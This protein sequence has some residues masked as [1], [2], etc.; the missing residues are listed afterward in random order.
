MTS[1]RKPQKTNRDESTPAEIPRE[2]DVPD[3]SATK[4]RKITPVVFAK[5]NRE[6]SDVLFVLGSSGGDW[7]AVAKLFHQKLAPIILVNGLTGKKYDETGQPLAH[8]IRDEL[9]GFG[10]PPS[11]ILTQDKS[12]NTLEDVKFGKELLKRHG[13]NP[14]TI[15]FVS[16]SHHSGRVLLTLKRFFPATLL[17]AVTYDAIYEGAKVSA[18]N[19]WKNPVAKARVYGEYIRIQTYS[20]RGDIAKPS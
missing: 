2:L 12:T 13:I 8:Y 1:Q 10:V 19:W 5:N 9:I 20:A 11:A 18:I 3:L 6:R 4:I 15:L 17:Y 7:N 14:S 16:K